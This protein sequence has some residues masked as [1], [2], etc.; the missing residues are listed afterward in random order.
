MCS[1]EEECR[2]GKNTGRIMDTLVSSY[3][4]RN[5]A[6]V[7][8]PQKVTPSPLTGKSSGVIAELARRWLEELDE[9]RIKS[10]NIQG[11]I[12]GEMKWRIESLHEAVQVLPNRIEAAGDVDY[13]RKNNNQL[14]AQLRASQLEEVRMREDLNSCE[15]KIRELK[16]EIRAL[17]D[18][19][20]SRSVSPEIENTRRTAGGNEI[21]RAKK[22]GECEAGPSQ[23]RARSGGRGTRL[24]S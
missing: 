4:L 12:S 1:N 18:R 24:K 9:R 11:Q 16:K 22:A 8:L 5:S 13:L 2:L 21:P 10:G 3:N 19:R 7:S 20:G 15:D 23:N 17:K 14:S 6:P